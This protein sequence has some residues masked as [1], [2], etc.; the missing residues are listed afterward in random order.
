[1][2]A[3]AALRRLWDEQSGARAA[4]RVAATPRD[5]ISRCV[6]WVFGET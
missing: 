5:T 1:M 4:A 3:A 2:R 6:A